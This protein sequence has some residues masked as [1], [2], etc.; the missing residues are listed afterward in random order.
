MQDMSG[1]LQACQSLHDLELGK[2][3][4]ESF[5]RMWVEHGDSDALVLAFGSRLEQKSPVHKRGC[6]REMKYCRQLDALERAQGGMHRLRL[7]RRF[8]PR[9]TPWR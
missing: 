5:R 7:L 1:G 3:R 8:L 6:T 4:T 9:R 2:L